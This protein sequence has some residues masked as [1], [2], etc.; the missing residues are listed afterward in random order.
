MPAPRRTP[1]WSS[2]PGA[3]PS[4]SSRSSPPRT[5]PTIKV[6]RSAFLKLAEAELAAIPEEFRELF[7]D[8]S[9]EVRA[10]PGREA[11]RWKGS[12]T[13]LGLYTGLTRTEMAG[14][15]SGT[16]EPARVILYQRNIESL[17]SS[18]AEL[19][20]QIASTLRH[21]IAHHFGFDEEDIRRASPEDA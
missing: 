9:V 2:S 7:T 14:P 10:A 5:F 1:P 19:A 15:Y 3:A 16:H 8:L 12:R 11:G 21:E 6:T 13:L 17:A 18:R 4:A 20:G